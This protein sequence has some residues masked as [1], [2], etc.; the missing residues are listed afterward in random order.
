MHNHLIL[1]SENGHAY[2]PPVPC[3]RLS[4]NGG[5]I[6]DVRAICHEVVHDINLPY[7]LQKSF[8]EISYISYTSVPDILCLLTISGEGLGVGFAKRCRIIL[9][10][11]SIYVVFLPHVLCSGSVQ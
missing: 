10:L 8:H 9:H 7:T 11:S 6:V 3:R 5:F 2:F 1:I 4:G